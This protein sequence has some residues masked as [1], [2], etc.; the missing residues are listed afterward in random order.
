[1]A[2]NGIALSASLQDVSAKGPVR[3]FHLIGSADCAVAFEVGLASNSSNVGRVKDPNAAADLVLK[4]PAS[5]SPAFL[6]ASSFVRYKV[7]QG[8]VT[9]CWMD[10]APMPAAG[11]DG[12]PAPRFNITTTK[13]ANFTAAAFDL[14]QCDP[15][16]GAFTVTLPE[17]A[18]VLP[19]TPIAVKNVTTSTTAITIENSASDTIDG[20]ASATM[21]TSKAITH[22]ISDG[23]SNWIKG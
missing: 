18:S 10:A 16:G 22:W 17:A 14:V 4:G 19:G 7:L 5:S 2:A 12:D 13:T 23:V 3:S 8:T 11:A 20:S 1:M 15:S 21:S 9:T 6:E